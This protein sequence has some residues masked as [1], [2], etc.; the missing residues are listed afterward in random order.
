LRDSRSFGV[1][2]VD[3]AKKLVA[4]ACYDKRHACVMP[5]SICSRFHAATQTNSGKITTF[6]G[7]SRF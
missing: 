5:V 7:S 3:T 1:I 4:S 6:I 2:D